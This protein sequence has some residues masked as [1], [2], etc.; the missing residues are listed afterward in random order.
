MLL[1]DE[2]Q[3]L[4]E[5]GLHFAGVLYD[6]QVFWRIESAHFTTVGGVADGVG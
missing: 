1:V 2:M 3:Y 6:C 4:V 5:S